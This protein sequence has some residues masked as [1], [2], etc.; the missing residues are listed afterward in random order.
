MDQ[1]KPAAIEE[2]VDDQAALIRALDSSHVLEPGAN[3]CSGLTELVGNTS[4]A[5]ID[6]DEASVNGRTAR[7]DTGRGDRRDVAEFRHHGFR[8]AEQDRAFLFAIEK[9]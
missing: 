9:I 8:L 4:V 3:R 5:A 2:H 7:F 1:V 6:G